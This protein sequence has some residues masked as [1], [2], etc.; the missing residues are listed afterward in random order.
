MVRYRMAIIVITVMV[1]IVVMMTMVVVMEVVLVMKIV[2]RMMI[3]IMLVNKIFVM[4]LQGNTQQKSDTSSIVTRAYRSRREV[5]TN[6]FKV[7]IE[8]ISK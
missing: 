7:V 2:A 3:M 5:T 4:F 6:S 8:Y 1:V